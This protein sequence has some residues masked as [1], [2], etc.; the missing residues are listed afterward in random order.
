LAWFAGALG[1]PADNREETMNKY[2]I[3]AAALVAFT[4]P[5]FAD[6]LPPAIDL[7]P[8]QCTGDYAASDV[9][10][11]VE[12]SP[13][14]HLLDIRALYMKDMK[15]LGHTKDELRCEAKLVLNISPE[16]EAFEFKYFYQDGHL[17]IWLTPKD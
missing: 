8:L 14:G 1:N 3:T 11:L 12:K 17:L 4:V 16:G 10:N 6:E 2:L 7:T 13:M 9:S 5:A 15:E